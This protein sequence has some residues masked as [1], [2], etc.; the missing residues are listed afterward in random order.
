MSRGF[1]QTLAL[2]SAALLLFVQAVP[3]FA[4][5]PCEISPE[6]SCCSL[7]DGA[8]EAAPDAAAAGPASSCCAGEAH[9]EAPV[10][11]DHASGCCAAESAGA[12]NTDGSSRLRAPCCERTTFDT[13]L[14]LATVPA[15]S[16]PGP[17]ASEVPAAL[18]TELPAPTP[19]TAFARPDHGSRAGPAVPEFVGHTIL[20][21]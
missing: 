9:A 11:E 6:R 21:L 17:A 13:D 16:A 18:P 5:C 3:A 15:E 4:L 20:L 1:R 2:L 7:R 19:P 8:A 14:S 10:P 12:Q